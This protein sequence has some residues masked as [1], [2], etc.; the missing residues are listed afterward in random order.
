V[1]SAFSAASAGAA[2]GVAPVAVG[3]DG[4]SEL[5]VMGDKKTT[6]AA[7]A[8]QRSRSIQQFANELLTMRQTLTQP[9]GADP[10]RP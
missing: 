4:G 5:A 8:P 7:V 6:V 9:L 2:P 1:A 10:G 3:A